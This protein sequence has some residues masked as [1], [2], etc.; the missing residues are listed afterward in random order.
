MDGLIDATSIVMLDSARR[1][2]PVPVLARWLPGLG[3][4]ATPVADVTHGL[5]DGLA[6]A[7]AAV[8]P[9]VAL[10]GSYELSL[11]VSSLLHDVALK[12]F[13]ESFCNTSGTCGACCRRCSE[14]CPPRTC[15]MCNT[16]GSRRRRT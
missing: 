3:I 16:L 5:G 15:N 8:W 4:A 1:T 10:V 6:G 11:G 7:T 2:V 9:A 12:R 13:T 14:A